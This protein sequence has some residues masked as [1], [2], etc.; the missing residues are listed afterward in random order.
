MDTVSFRNCE[1]VE[2][3]FFYSMLTNVAFSIWYFQYN[4]YST[5]VHSHHYK[6]SIFSAIKLEIF[7]SSLKG[8]D[9]NMFL[10]L[11]DKYDM[12]KWKRKQFLHFS[13]Y[14]TLHLKTI[15]SSHVQD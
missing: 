6:I 5:F 4:F 3:Y 7:K 11:R 13:L 9:I 1:H 14:S 2:W 10:F 12:Y 8:S 15:L